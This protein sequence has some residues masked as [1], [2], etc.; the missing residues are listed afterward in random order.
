VSALG[1]E[2][3][4][5]WD[6]DAQV[7][8][9]GPRV[10]SAARMVMD[11]YGAP[12]SYETFS[13]RVTLRVA[14][15]SNDAAHLTLADGSSIMAPYARRPD[16]VL[17]TNGIG[18]ISLMLSTRAPERV[19]HEVSMFMP[20][21]LAVRETWFAPDPDDSNRWHS[22]LGLELQ[23]D[24]N[25]HI[26]GGSAPGGVTLI[27]ADPRALVWDNLE[28][29]RSQPRT[30]RRS[31]AGTQRTDVHIPAAAGE[32]GAVVTR[33]ASS[34]PRRRSPG[35]LFLQGT[36]RPNRDGWTPR[37]QTAT[38]DLVDAIARAGFV[39]LRCDSR[40]SG[41]TPFGPIDAGLSGLV[42]DAAAA[43][44]F[45]T[46]ERAT[47]GAA[48]F[49]VGH[50]LGAI[51]ALELATRLEGQGRPPAGL[52]LLAPP[53]RRL[54]SLLA[55]QLRREGVR[56]GFSQEELRRRDRVIADSLRRLKSSTSENTLPALMAWEGMSTR[57]LA[58]LLRWHPPRHLERLHVPVLICQGDKDIQVSLTRD[59][60]RLARVGGKGQPPIELRVFPDVDHLLRTEHESPSPERY[61]VPRPTNLVL[62]ASLIEWLR[63]HSFAVPRYRKGSSRPPRR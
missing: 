24:D 11:E 61:F 27:R 29:L 32:I 13:D 60:L 1:W 54:G 58:D 26:Q 55:E 34:R 18:Q 40:G 52:V 36:G 19:R 7:L 50:S 43:W 21:A 59:A 39:T 22:G 30:K 63:G 8:G 49:L 4:C 14:E 38:A 17:Q 25:G 35:L 2:F 20:D 6:L 9:G 16:G 42:D 53:G 56:L 23:L 31:A 51:V 33:P 46:A 62:I 45:L 10:Q 28:R 48:R 15:F 44:E 37:L 3:V 5:A 12:L 47:S 41:D 57:L